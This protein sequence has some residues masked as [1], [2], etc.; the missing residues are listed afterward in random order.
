M[1]TRIEIDGFKSFENFALDLPPF[2]V[3]IGTDAS[4]KSNLLDA[5]NFVSAAATRGLD[6]AVAE[7]RGDPRGLFR[8]R[9]DGT[10]ADRMTFAL[11][12]SLAELPKGVPVRWRY[13]MDLAWAEPEG[14]LEGIV[15][16]T[17]RLRGPHG[18]EI[19]LEV[20]PEL[21][22]RFLKKE[23][24]L[25]EL[26]LFHKNAGPVAAN[27]RLVPRH[28]WDEFA[29]MRFLHLE[30][31]SLR[32]ASELGGPSHDLHE[33]LS[34][35]ARRGAP[36][37]HRVPRYDHRPGG[38][39]RQP[40]KP[41]AAAA[42]GCGCGA[43][44]R[45]AMAAGH[46]LGAR[47]VPG[48]GGGTGLMRSLSCVLIREGPSDDWFLTILLRRALEDLVIESFPACR[49]VQEVRSLPKAGN[50]SP[51]PKAVIDALLGGAGLNPNGSG[52]LQ[53]FYV[54][55]AETAGIA[56]LRKVPAFQQWWNDMI[57]ALEGLGYQHG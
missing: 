6:P 28:L 29:R 49:E 39:C 38:R 11:E 1:I 57:E 40:G 18:E 41:G 46:G 17:Q 24:G 34:G 25:L 13:E 42:R 8:R 7:V 30:A 16:L 35:G 43:R 48:R 54:S 47:Q 52:V 37:E 4:G 3:L 31:G 14:A 23:P 50:R 32:R 10:R 5:L 22:T 19:A 55:V 27:D 20:A 12:F 45:R 21:Q 53:N 56:E 51:E 26:V 9:G 15:A 36:R 33:P 44:G 2:L